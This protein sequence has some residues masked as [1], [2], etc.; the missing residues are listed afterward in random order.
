M[1][2]CKFCG[3]D[4][5]VGFGN[6]KS[7]CNDECYK[8]FYGM[9]KEKSVAC[10]MCGKSLTGLRRTY[11]SDECQK[12]SKLSERYDEH[13]KPQATTYPVNVKKQDRPKKMTL[14]EVNELARAEGL[15]YGQYVAKHRLY[16]VMR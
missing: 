13:K 4:L 5:L 9:K 7:F 14:A 2:H 15:S 16:E 11:C 10:E 6:R 3:K 12:K 8:K 1:K